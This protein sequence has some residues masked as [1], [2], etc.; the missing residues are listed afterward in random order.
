MYLNYRDVRSLKMRKTKLTTELHQLQQEY[1][2]LKLQ[3]FNLSNQRSKYTFDC[4]DELDALAEEERELCQYFDTTSDALCQ[5][6]AQK[7]HEVNQAIKEKQQRIE[8]IKQK[9]ALLQRS[10]EGKRNQIDHNFQKIKVEFQEMQDFFFN[11]KQEMLGKMYK[12]RA[13]VNKLIQIKKDR[14]TEKLNN[15]QEKINKLSAEK[16]QYLDSKNEKLQRLSLQS[17]VEFHFEYDDSEMRDQ[18]KNIARQCNA[19]LNKA[20]QFS[21]KLNPL[22]QKFD[23]LERRINELIEKVNQT[24]IKISENQSQNS[25]NNWESLIFNLLRIKRFKKAIDDYTDYL[26]QTNEELEKKLRNEEE[27]ADQKVPGTN[28]TLFELRQEILKLSRQI[29]EEIN[30]YDKQ[31]KLIE[32]EHHEYAD[33][34][35]KEIKELEAKVASTK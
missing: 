12:L 20:H 6:Y 2:T 35:D 11:F 7:D 18:V 19:V 26:I 25:L 22:M 13:S 17:F 21:I 1:S 15:A 4:Q 32:K 14:A 24:K 3:I 10:E 9:L 23:F 5:S 31:L 30:E 34:A 16:K 8:E 29:S 33:R 28:M 27:N